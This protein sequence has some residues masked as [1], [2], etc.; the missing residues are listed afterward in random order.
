MLEPRASRPHMPGY[1]TLAA[2]QGSGLL[3]WSWALKRLRDSHEYWLSTVWPDG[4]PHLMPVWAVWHDEAL[5]F[6]SSAGARKIRNIRAGSAVSLATD[7]AL[8]P[9][10][11]EGTARVMKD[12]ASLRTFLKIMNDKYRTAYTID[13]LDPARNA[14]VRVRPRWAFGLVE[15]DFPGSPTRWEFR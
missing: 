13:F 4:R 6:S 1:G 11:I 14:T 10:V 3:P 9:V 15:G 7:D 5:W 8:N 2:D 12:T